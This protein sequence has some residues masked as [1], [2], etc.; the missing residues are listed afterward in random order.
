M[1][2]QS[3][4]T[5]ISALLLILILF[6]GIGIFCF[7]NLGKW[8]IVS[9][10]PADPVNVLFTFAGEN[11][12]I[13]YSKHLFRKNSDA[14]WIISYPSSKIKA[15][16]SRD[17]LDTSRICIIDTCTD[18]KAEVACIIQWQ[19]SH[20]RLLMSRSAPGRTPVIGLVSSW[21]HMRR[22]KLLLES[23]ANSE[24]YAVRFFPVQQNDSATGK[25]ENIW[26][27]N[28]TTRNIVVSEWGKII[29]IHINKTYKQAF[30]HV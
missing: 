27:K 14:L 11:T 29:F 8:L 19:H 26:W 9:D 28:E 13:T 23:Q 30:K 2:T 3:G 12:R 18:T 20:G 24:P 15:A 6:C 17:N 16:L 5:H 4:S 7:L 1:K 22:I 25:P 10:S 21:Y